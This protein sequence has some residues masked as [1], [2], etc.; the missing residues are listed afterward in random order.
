MRSNYNADIVRAKNFTSQDSTPSRTRSRG[1]RFV[2]GDRNLPPAV[3]VGTHP[4]RVIELGQNARQE[5]L[6]AA[7]PGP[8]A[9]GPNPIGSVG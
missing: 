8:F 3:P 6:S 5:P 4:N 2:V 7:L 9:P 1:V